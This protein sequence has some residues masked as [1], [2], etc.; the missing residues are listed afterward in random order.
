[1]VLLRGTPMQVHPAEVWDLL[2]LFGL[3][4]W[5]IVRRMLVPLH[6]IHLGP[7]TQV[8]STSI[9]SARPTLV[10][11][12][13]RLVPVFA[14][15]SVPSGSIARR[16]QRLRIRI[17]ASGAGRAKVPPDEGG[18]RSVCGLRGRL[19]SSDSR[20]AGGG[21]SPWARL[22][23]RHCDVFESSTSIDSYRIAL[24]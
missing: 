15:V 13:S 19:G 24:S 23:R 5:W 18:C 22:S 6:T 1:M 8:I 11:A 9:G 16:G 12:G 4:K 2:R 14:M 3:P 7:L 17:P 20:R 10:H 21:Q